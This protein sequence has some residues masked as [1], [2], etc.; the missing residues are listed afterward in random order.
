VHGVDAS[1]L[2]A[3]LLV[4]CLPAG[5]FEC[6]MW[7]LH[8]RYRPQKALDKTSFPTADAQTFMFVKQGGASTA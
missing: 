2:S 1:D 3:S 7:N 8:V 6:V 5:G 4:G